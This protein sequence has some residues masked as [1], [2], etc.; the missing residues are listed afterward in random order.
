MRAVWTG[1]ITFGL[2]NV[3][4]KAYGAVE[5]HDISFHQVHDKDGGRIRYERRCEVCGEEVEYK[6]IDKAYEEDGDTV[7]MT[8]EDFDALPEA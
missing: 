2:V 6:N 1:A 3:P 5:D 7:I 8:D 4:V